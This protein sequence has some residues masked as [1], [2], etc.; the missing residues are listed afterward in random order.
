M[1]LKEY[2]DLVAA[3]T[4]RHATISERAEA[5]QALDRRLISDRVTGTVFV[6]VFFGSG[7]AKGEATQL[8]RIAL[9]LKSSKH[10]DNAIA[11][12][13]VE[14]SNGVTAYSRRE[15]AAAIG[16]D[17][18]GMGSCT[19]FGVCEADPDCAYDCDISTTSGQGWR[20]V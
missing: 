5:K 9:G 8:V 18:V 13:T 12:A 1:T 4:D 20:R 2:Q 11:A 19:D 14:C 6:P 3:T 15:I 17:H 7:R 10:A 16:E